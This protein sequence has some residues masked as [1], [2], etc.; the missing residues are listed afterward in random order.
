M[1]KI[2]LL[3]NKKVL[4]AIPVLALI[5]ITAYFAFGAVTPASTPANT[6]GSIQYGSHVC[7]SKIDGE[8]NERTDYPCTH[9]LVVDSGL[10]AIRD[11]L[12]GNS[13][14]GNVNF[15]FIALGN[16]SN[17][18]SAA[19]PAVGDIILSAEYSG[20]NGLNRTSGSVASLGTGNWTVWNEFTSAVSTV[21]TN[22]TCLF[23][24]STGGTMLACNNFPETSLQGA[25]GD[26]LLINWTISITSG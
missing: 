8:T 12:R 4:F 2:G 24:Q 20:P 9:N 10:N 3:G 15:T 22:K 5:V 17:A 18:T 14:V 7:V 25:S 26:K 13:A 1:G 23:N 19:A 6:D 21:T 16:S 11:I